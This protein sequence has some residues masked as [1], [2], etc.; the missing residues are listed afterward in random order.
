MDST[1]EQ[2]FLRIAGDL[3]IDVLGG[4]NATILAYGQSGTGKT[5]TMEG[6]LQSNLNKGIIPRA[7]DAL[8]EGVTEADENIEFTFKVSYVEIY[9]EK[10]RDL[11]DEHRTKVN[12]TVREDK[13]KG[14]YIAGVTEEYVTSSDETLA[15]MY[16]GASNRAVAATGL[17]SGSSRSHSVFTITSGKLVLV[18]LAGSEMVRKSNASGQQLEEAKMINKSLSALGQVINALT[19][20]NINHVPYR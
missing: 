3:I 15:V 16:M 9:L 5:H 13:I 19:D 20:K 17:N 1:Q 6:D 14:I 7:V 11:L 18:D 4:Y 8:F 10:I 12:L 2:V